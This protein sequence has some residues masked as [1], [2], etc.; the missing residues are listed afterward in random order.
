MGRFLLLVV[1]AAVLGSACGSSDPLA[2]DSSLSAVGA[3]EPLPLVRLRAEPYSFTYSSGLDDR[4]HV[5]VRD[6][7]TWSKLWQAIWLRHSPLPPR[8]EVDFSRDM[9]VVAA[10]G[11]RPTG[12]YEIYVDSAYQRTDHLEVVIRTVAP[13]EG[14]GRFQ[15]VT[16]PVD[17]ARLRRSSQ[18]VR[19]RERSTIHE[20]E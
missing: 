9:L 15:A 1:V 13:G 14:C 16:Q 19:Y 2:S 5:M 8:P 12:G 7:S 10:L 17:I 4:L 11:T 6:V 3:G 18:P 20:C